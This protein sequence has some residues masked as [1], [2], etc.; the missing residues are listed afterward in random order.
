MKQIS[1]LITILVLTAL[2]AGCSSGGGDTNE[3]APNAEAVSDLSIAN[4]SNANVALAEGTRLLD[5]NQTERAIEFLQHAVSLDPHLA[6]GHFKLGIAFSLLEMQYEQE[7]VITETSSNTNSGRTKTRSER[8]FGRAVTAYEKWLVANPADDAAHFN[9]GRT[10]SKLTK[11]EEAEKA[12][13]Q[14]VKLKPYDSEYQTELGAILIKLAQYRDAIPPLKKAIELDEGN[15][16][17]IDL[18]E[19]AEAGRKR[20]DYIPANKNANQASNSKN[21]NSDSNVNSN[22]STE[23]NSTTKTPEPSSKVKKNE[24]DTARPRVVANK[25]K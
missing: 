14:A 7:G 9:L 12:F 21:S 3:Q 6:E 22:T 25:P 4:I 18:L 10:Y 23:S 11:D 5:E 17:A 24:P 1:L 13:K 2:A 20:V 19:D 16:R 8:A 15:A